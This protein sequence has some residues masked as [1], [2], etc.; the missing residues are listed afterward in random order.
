MGLTM[1]F[2]VTHRSW[3]SQINV[4]CMEL[5]PSRCWVKRV[6][7]LRGSVRVAWSDGILLYHSCNLIG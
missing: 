5:E 6:D 4:G 1:N 2:Y 3:R 7:P